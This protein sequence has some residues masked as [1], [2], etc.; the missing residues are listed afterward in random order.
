M[1]FPTLYEQLAPLGPIPPSEW[2]RAESFAREQAVERKAHFLRPG[3]PADRFAVV[4]QGVFRLVRVSARGGESVKA[5]RAEGELLGAYAEMLQR[6]PSMTSI[7]ALE[8]ARVLVFRTQDFQALEEG[9]TCW[10]R[11]ARRV[12]ERHFLLKERRE[13]EFLELSA[14]ERLDTFWAEHP[15]L[16]GRVPQRDVAAYLGITE[17]AL[18]RIMSRRRKRTE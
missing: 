2:E 17:V 11:V 14:E 13:Q 16:R 6:Q 10:V 8:P 5:F 18:S 9:H 1:R 3:D 12:A 7:E 15:H 4:L